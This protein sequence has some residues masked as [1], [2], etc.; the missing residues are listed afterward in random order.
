MFL[1]CSFFKKVMEGVSKSQDHVENFLVMIMIYSDDMT[2]FC[3]NIEV[4][5]LSPIIMEVKH[6]CL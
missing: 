3:A 4:I 2:L 6:G 1:W 5:T